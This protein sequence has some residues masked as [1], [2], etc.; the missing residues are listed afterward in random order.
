MLVRS[1]IPTSARMKESRRPST[2]A[3]LRIQSVLLCTGKGLGVLPGDRLLDQPRSQPAARQVFKIEVSGWST[4]RETDLVG[5]AIWND[6]VLDELDP[7]PC[8]FAFNPIE[9]RG[10]FACQRSAQ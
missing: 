9:A 6:L 10:R 4:V 3:C 2:S 5:A 1:S 7:H 8:F